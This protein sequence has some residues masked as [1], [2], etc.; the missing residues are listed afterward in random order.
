[1]QQMAAHPGGEVVGPA[2]VMPLELDHELTT[3]CRTGESYGSLRRLGAGVR[4]A[5][6]LDARHESRQ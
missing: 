6:L 2:V 4:K 1:M 5:Q 3:G